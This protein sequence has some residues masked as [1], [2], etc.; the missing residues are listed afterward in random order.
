LKQPPLR[1]DGAAGNRRPAA[2]SAHQP[3]QK[4]A[5]RGRPF[6]KGQ[7]GNPSG[8]PRALAELGELARQRTAAAIAALARALN[9]PK[10]AVAAASELLDRGWGKAEQNLDIGGELTL[11]RGGIDAPPDIPETRDEWLRRREAELAALSGAV[12]GTADEPPDPIRH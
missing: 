4:G 12:A 2:I 10:T 6:V 9:D 1:R 11:Y 5:P 7:A 8:R 3:P